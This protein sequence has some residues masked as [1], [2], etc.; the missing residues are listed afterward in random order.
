MILP[1]LLPGL[2]KFA[3][4]YVETYGDPLV[5]RVLSGRGVDEVL[6]FQSFVWIEA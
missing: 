2:S 5:G 3:N 6:W 1:P 4:W